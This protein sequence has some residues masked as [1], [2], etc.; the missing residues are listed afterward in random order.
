M[1]IDNLRPHIEAARLSAE[2][3]QVQAQTA[4]DELEAAREDATMEHLAAERGQRVAEA[5]RLAAE[6]ARDAAVFAQAGAE[7]AAREA[8]LAHCNLQDFLAMAAHDIRGP[9]TAIAGYADLL[10]FPTTLL[11]QRDVALEAIQTAV[12]QMARLVEDIVDAG[13]VGAGA[14][15]L[16]LESVDLVPLVQQVASGQ[17]ITTDKHRLVVDAPERLEGDWD[18]VRLAQVMSNLISNAIKYSPGGGDIRIS[19]REE[20]DAALVCVADRGRGIR[21]ADVRLL[22]RPFTR[23]ISPKEQMELNGTGLG[24]YI[25][26]GIVKA[27]GGSI[28]ATSEGEDEGSEF[29][30]RLPSSETV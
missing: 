25:S 22:F 21:A 17:Q 4:L 13:R 28:W 24:L 5:A 6:A 7:E 9:L 20:H 1:G 26:F 27:H 3:A 15:T 30:V 29:C 16:H 19:V 18:P 14:F 2:R 23:L 12:F 10:A 11:D 8:E